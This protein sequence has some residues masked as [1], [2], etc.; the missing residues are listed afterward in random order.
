MRG[1]IDTNVWVSAFLAQR[2]YPAQLIEVE[3]KQLSTAIGGQMPQLQQESY[4]RM[5][6]TN[7]AAK[8]HKNEYAR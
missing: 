7:R 6:N 4:Q 1:V 3:P 8:V 5:R 2:G